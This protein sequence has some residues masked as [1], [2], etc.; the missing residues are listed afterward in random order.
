MK[1]REYLDMLSQPGA[2]TGWHFLTGTEPSIKKLADDIGFRYKYNSVNDQYAHPTGLTV[3]TPKGQISRYLFGVVYE[4]KDTRLA[5]TEAGQG[6]IGS[7][8]D[9]FVLACYHYD[10]QTGRYGLAIF[11]LMQVLGFSTIFILGGFMFLAFRKDIGAPKLTRADVRQMVAE[12]ARR[13]NEGATSST[14]GTS[15]ERLEG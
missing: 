4:P 10:P 13:E 14:S 7:I 2:E 12:K 6:R 3:L 8:S 1:K 5:L 11:R 15:N 9:K